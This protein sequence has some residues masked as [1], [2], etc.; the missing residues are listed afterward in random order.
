MSLDRDSL[1]L[2]DPA[3]P[4]NALPLLP[5]VADIETRAIMRKC[6]AAGRAL[7]E[8]KLASELIPNV[9]VLINTIPLREA[10]DSSAIENIVTTNDRLFRYAG[11]DEQAADPATKEAL[12]YRR[13]LWEGF[14]AI[15][16]RPL[17][18]NTAVASCRTIKGT[19]L[20]IRRTPGTTLTND[21][22]GTVI[23][24]PPDG[25]DLLRAKLKNWEEFL[26]TADEIDPLIRMA[27]GHYQFEAIHP[28][29]DGNGRTGR[30][31]N[32]LYLI[33]KGLLTIP[34]LYLSRYIIAH[35]EDYYRLLQGVTAQGEWE[36]WILYMLEAV[37]QTAQ[38]TTAKIRAI[39]SLMDHTTGYVCGAA[40]KIY[41]YELV[42]LIF[43]QPYCRI[44]HIVDMGFAQRRTAS[45]YLK[46]LCDIGVLE[47]RKVGRDKLFI[48]TRYLD[49]LIADDHDFAPYPAAVRRPAAEL[50]S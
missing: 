26:H 2:F 8:L 5:P 9:D 16:S 10:R 47:E 15:G 21:S 46:E 20:G 11:V 24:T 45:V 29:P 34:V 4:Y 38:W 32:I 41:R 33:D 50:A 36:A 18:T 43:L 37:E 3:T 48:H 25:E 22:T 28:F 17:T 1:P 44:G 23:Y 14:Q 19:E 42:E 6:V 35:R 7:A 39:K 12:R 13:A 30:I 49:L 40:P 31:L 27:V